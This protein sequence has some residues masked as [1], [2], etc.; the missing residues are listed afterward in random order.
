MN[1][2]TSHLLRPYREADAA[3]CA[4]VLDRAWHAG[5]PYAPRTVDLAVFRRE[6]AGRELVVA[7]SPAGAVVGFAGVD[8][9]GAFIHHLYVAPEAA[10]RGVG[11]GL[12]AAALRLAG[13]RATLKCQLRNTRALRFYEREGWVRGETGTDGVEPWVRFL[14]SGPAEASSLHSGPFAPI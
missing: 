11:Q 9:P 6:T 10:G 2:P 12:L 7:V 13:G 8:V 1:E 4:D 14:S 5:H 3:A